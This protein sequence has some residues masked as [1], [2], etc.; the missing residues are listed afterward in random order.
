MFKSIL[1][2]AV[3]NF[4]F[5]PGI[6]GIETTSAR[7]R[8]RKRERKRKK[9]KERETE[10]YNKY[11]KTSYPYIAFSCESQVI[12][13]IPFEIMVPSNFSIFVIYIYYASFYSYNKYSHFD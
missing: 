5:L 11:T 10:I 9:G 7:E 2:S 1:K 8:E 13:S 3:N 4:W 6:V 12:C